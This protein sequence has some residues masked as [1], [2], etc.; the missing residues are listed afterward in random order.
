MSG[1]VVLDLDQPRKPPRVLV[2]GAGRRFV[3]MTD[4]QATALTALKWTGRA[5]VSSA[6]SLPLAQFEDVNGCVHW[7]TADWL[8]RMGFARMLK[9][10]DKVGRRQLAAT[11]RGKRVVSPVAPWNE[12]LV[13]LDADGYNEYGVAMCECKRFGPIHAW[14]PGEWCSPKRVVPDATI[15]LDREREEIVEAMPCAD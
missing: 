3:G 11:A 13:K 2:S 7:K 14:E 5:A 15:D 6:T 8:C 9:R 1:G 10:R 4:A 12:C